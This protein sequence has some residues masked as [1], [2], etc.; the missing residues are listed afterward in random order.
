M[1][2]SNSPPGLRPPSGENLGKKVG[3]KKGKLQTKKRK[4][5]SGPKTGLRPLIRALKEGRVVW[6][7]SPRKGKC[8]G[9]R[10]ISTRVK[11]GS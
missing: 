6:D 8:V 9:E 7:L 2:M 1:A 3:G 11:P 10:K 4:R 5:K